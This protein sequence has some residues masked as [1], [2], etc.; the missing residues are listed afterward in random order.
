ME[1][2]LAFLAEHSIPYERFDHPAVFT[3]EESEKLSPMPGASTKNLFLRNDKKTEYFLVSVG[4]EKRA[5]LKALGVLLNAKLSFGSPEDLKRLLGV[6]PGSV[7]LFGALH[8]MDKAVD[9]I[10]DR[11]VWEAGAMQCHPLVNTATLIMKTTDMEN[12]FKAMD[13][14]FRVLKVPAI[15]ILQGGD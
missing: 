7:T 10:I 15:S 9:I 3:C 12:F 8:D 4:H 6:E 11:E 13:H 5:D 14:A 2:L 1:T